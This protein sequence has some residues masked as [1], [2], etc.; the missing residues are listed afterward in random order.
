VTRHR[1]LVAGH[2]VER[3]STTKVTLSEVAS[4]SQRQCTPQPLAATKQFGQR[5][6]RLVGGF[7]EILH[8]ACRNLV[9]RSP[10]LFCLT[11]G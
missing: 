4:F 1:L 10:A 8:R 7:A 5:G 6:H 9:E 2:I 11:A 3:L